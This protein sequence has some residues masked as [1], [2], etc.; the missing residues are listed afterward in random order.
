MLRVAGEGQVRGGEGSCMTGILGG[1]RPNAVLSAAAPPR[2][3]RVL[4]PLMSCL[5]VLVVDTHTSCSSTCMQPGGADM[6]GTSICDSVT[7]NSLQNIPPPPSISLAEPPSAAEAN[8]A[9]SSTT[10]RRSSLPSRFIRRGYLHRRRQLQRR[11]NARRSHRRP[12]LPGIETPPLR[13]SEPRAP[14]TMTRSPT[15]PRAGPAA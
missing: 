15:N 14:G 11:C 6:T 3:S 4:T 5:S 7:L 2:S 13:G 9:R 1:V 8:G 10:F 12:L